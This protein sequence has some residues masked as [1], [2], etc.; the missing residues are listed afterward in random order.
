MGIARIG[1]VFAKTLPQRV[2]ASG[3]HW[4]S[5]RQRTLRVGQSRG[6]FCCAYLLQCSLSERPP[7]QLLGVL[8]VSVK[9]LPVPFITLGWSQLFPAGRLVASASKTLRIDKGFHHPHRVAKALLPVLGQ[10]LT[11]QLQNPRGQVGPLAGRGQ[12]QKARI[13]RNEMPPLFNLTGRPMQPLIPKFDVQGRRT[14]DQQGHPLTLVLGHI[15]Q[16]PSNR[17]GILEIMLGGQLLIETL[18]LGV[19]DEANG[20]CLQQQRLRR[21]SVN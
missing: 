9:V 14:E 4:T 7:P 8:G 17:I 11:D 13:L 10:S 19:L 20:Y 15:A 1:H 6:Q 21:D 3:G 18:S 5:R 12:H 2:Q 16:H